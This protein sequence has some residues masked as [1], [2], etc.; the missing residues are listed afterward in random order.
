MSSINPIFASILATT[1]TDP[2]I[3]YRLCYE[4]ASPA[5]VASIAQAKAFQDILAQE[6]ASRNLP[7]GVPKV[8][9]MEGLPGFTSLGAPSVSAGGVFRTYRVEQMLADGY[10]DSL[11]TRLEFIFD[12]TGEE[13]EDGQ[14]YGARRFEVA[15]TIRAWF[16]NPQHVI[17]EF[18]KR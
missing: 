12:G 4:G 3:K 9:A 17:D 8:V 1:K 6:F 11:Q 14:R 7:L 15:D 2:L 18:L 13:D 16:Q 5:D 10:P